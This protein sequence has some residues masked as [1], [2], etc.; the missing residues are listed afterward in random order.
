MLE[1]LLA[2]DAA[3][4]AA[5]PHAVQEVNASR[6]AS[7]RTLFLRLDDCPHVPRCHIAHEVVLSRRPILCMLG[8]IVIVLVRVEHREKGP[9]PLAA[10]LAAKGVATAEQH[11]QRHTAGPDVLS[12]GIVICAA[13]TRH[14]SVIVRGVGGCEKARVCACAKGLG[15]R[16]GDGERA[17]E[18][19]TEQRHRNR[20]RAGGKRGVKETCAADV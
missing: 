11:K 4:G 17:G 9:A 5:V 16:W 7:W 1:D 12:A 19:N 6:A 18:R 15:G 14:G 3:L 2:S 10:V 13:P 8:G 20:K